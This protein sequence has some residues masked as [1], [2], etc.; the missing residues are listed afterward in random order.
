MWNQGLALASG[1]L[2]SLW[3]QFPT[4]PWGLQLTDAVDISGKRLFSPKQEVIQDGGAGGGQRGLAAAL[5]CGRWPGQQE[6]R[7]R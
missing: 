5:S 1:C 2:N 7:R 4:T 6:V 3:L